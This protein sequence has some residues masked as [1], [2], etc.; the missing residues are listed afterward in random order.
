M[1]KMVVDKNLGGLAGMQSEKAAQTNKCS[2]DLFTLNRAFTR[3][4]DDM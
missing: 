3:V 4:S 2:D 1:H